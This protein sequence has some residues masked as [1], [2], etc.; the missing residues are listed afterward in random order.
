M[1]SAGEA[2]ARLQFLHVVALKGRVGV[3]EQDQ[4]RLPRDDLGG[5]R[6]TSAMKRWRQ[7]RF[8]W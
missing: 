1:D 8:L 7:K 6:G 5:K 2:G 4:V 3:V